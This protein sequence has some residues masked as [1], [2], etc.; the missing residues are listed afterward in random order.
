[1]CHL[2]ELHAAI[3]NRETLSLDPRLGVVSSQF[4]PNLLN[5]LETNRQMRRQRDLQIQ[6]VCLNACMCVCAC[7]RQC[8]TSRKL[9]SADLHSALFPLSRSEKQASF[10]RK[11][12]GKTRQMAVQYSRA[13]CG[14][15]EKRAEVPN[16]GLSHHTAIT[17]CRVSNVKWK[18]TK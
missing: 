2:Q 18:N 9:L 10:A 13:T 17:M 7:V 11:R 12:R 6:E 14:S 8:V 16:K 3:R 4:L 15:S 1:M 5:T